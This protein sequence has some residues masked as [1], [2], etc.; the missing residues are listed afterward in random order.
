MRKAILLMLLAA[1][2]AAGQTDL[3]VSP[4]AAVTCL[5]TGG[6]LTSDGFTLVP[7]GGA[8]ATG[9]QGIPGPA[10]PMGPVGPA[11]P[12]GAVGPPGAPGVRCAQGVPGIQGPP[13]PAGPPGTGTPGRRP[14]MCSAADSGLPPLPGT[15]GTTLPALPTSCYAP[16]YPSTSTS[17]TVSTAAALQSAVTSAVCGEKIVVSANTVYSVSG[18]LV[19][20]GT[21]C[22]KTNPI[23]VVSSAIRSLPQYVTTAQSDASWGGIAQA[24]GASTITLDVNAASI[25][26]A[27]N[28]R[29]IAITGGA[30]SGQTGTVSS[31]VGSTKVATMTG[32]WSTPPNGTSAF[33][34]AS[35]VAPTVIC[36]GSGCNAVGIA[37]NASGWYF[38]GIDFTVDPNATAVYP[39]ISMGDG[40]V[41]TAAL[42]TYITFDRCWAHPTGSV[43]VN[44]SSRGIDLNAVYGTVMFSNVWGSVATYKDTQGILVTNTTGPLLITGNHIEGGAENVA[45]FNACA[46]GV[47][48]PGQ[49]LPGC[50][51]P[52]DI[53][54]TR[55]HIQK[56][57]AWYGQPTVGP[58][59]DVKNLFECKSCQRVLVD[60]NWIDTTFS[61]GQDE[62]IILNCFGN[63][64]FICADVTFTSNLIT[65]APQV[66]VVAGNLTTNTGNRIEFRNNLAI[67]INNIT[68][69]GSGVAFGFGTTNY[70]I[71]DHNTVA[72]TGD[73]A[74]NYLTGLTTGDSLPSTNLNFRYTNNFNYASPAA[75][76]TL[77]GSVIADFISPTLGGDVFVGDYWPCKYS[78]GATCTTYY[79]PAYPAYPAGISVVDS[80]AVP[81]RGQPGCNAAGKPIGG[82]GGVL[83]TGCWPLDWALVGFADF[84][85]GN[86]GTN[87][88]GMQLLSSSPW[89]NAGTDGLDVGANVAAVLAAVA[90][91]Q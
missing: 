66:G 51:S 22:P 87:L 29:T 63:G 12:A 52:S 83:A 9:P 13:G 58:H 56:L 37:D 27:Y 45:I 74:H 89:H 23:L 25:N 68:W 24:G 2:L 90:G 88:T 30:G 76:G 43:N 17:T 38:A 91:V 1:G 11:G 7:C 67:D 73:V 72:N 64:V 8:S 50:P 31:Y 41:T 39:I 21:I 36:T 71:I 61:Q 33:V 15:P 57:A 49:S 55:N 80:S 84:A 18:G 5:V 69:G 34:V 48:V 32:A 81:V 26:G 20:P 65:H 6:K 86:A 28:G 77:P 60:S 10:G 46:S 62:A 19:V 85:G 3:C 78:S 4:A 42:P 70:F 79:T 44:G 35:L 53:T 75:N 54:V 40:T 16:P 59:Y 82:P 47:Y 14:R